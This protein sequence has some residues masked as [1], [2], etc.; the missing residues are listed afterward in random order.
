MY[1]YTHTRTRIY[2]HTQLDKVMDIADRSKTPNHAVK[3]IAKV[4]F[5]ATIGHCKTSLPCLDDAP[6]KSDSSP[7]VSNTTVS[8][9]YLHGFHSKTRIFPC[10]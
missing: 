10:S 2:I 7:L 9:H 5:H 8:A 1:V 4:C 3:E 6:Q